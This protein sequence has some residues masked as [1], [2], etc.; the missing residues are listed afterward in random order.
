MLSL[1][2][3]NDITKLSDRWKDKR[4]DEV[5]RLLDQVG[6]NNAGIR[7]ILAT[8]DFKIFEYDD[9]MLDLKGFSLK[10]IKNVDI[11]GVNFHYSKSI[12]Q[13]SLGSLM[14]VV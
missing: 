7:N 10:V 14:L 13:E 5:Q 12:H 1:I 9:G 11:E 3:S 4:L 8:P 2:I 6:S